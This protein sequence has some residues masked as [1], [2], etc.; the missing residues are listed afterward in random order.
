MKICKLLIISLVC[1]SICSC[2]KDESDSTGNPNV[3]TFIKQLK[4]GTYEYVILPEF[5]SQ[6]IPALLEYR[7][8]TRHL[9]VYPVNPISSYWGGDCELGTYVLWVIESI[10]VRSIEKNVMGF[11]SQNPVLALKGEEF[12]IVSKE[13][14]HRIASEAYYNWWIKNRHKPFNEFCTIDPLKSTA[15]KWY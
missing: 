9:S 2:D 14:S 10:R 13:E 8:N 5:T 15:Y 6:D 4:A 12:Q 3:D 11:P 1:F 7:D